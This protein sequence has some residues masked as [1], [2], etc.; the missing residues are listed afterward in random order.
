MNQRGSKVVLS[1][2]K[3]VQSYG[4]YSWAC[5]R[6]LRELN[7]YHI[8]PTAMGVIWRSELINLIN[9]VMFLYVSSSGV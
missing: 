1:E 3:T 5:L 4:A 7:I 9:D 6:L 2:L 8:A